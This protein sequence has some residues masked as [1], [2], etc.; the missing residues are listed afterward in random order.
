M[1]ESA[2]VEGFKSDI[3]FGEP[4]WLEALPARVYHTPQYGEVPV[5]VEKLDR[6]VANF[7]NNVRGQDIA[8]NYDH[9]ND[10]AKGNKAAGWFRDFA[11]KPSSSDPNQMSLYAAV[12]F[13]DEAQ[14]EIKSGAW[15][16]FSMEWD[17]DWMDNAG[18]SYKD[19]VVGAG[20]TNRPIAKHMQALPVNFS[21]TQ[22]QEL[23]DDTKKEFAVWSTAYVNDLP[24]SCFLYVEPGAKTKDQRHLPYKDKNGKID[25]PHLR[26]AIARIPQ[27][28]GI[29]DALKSRLQSKAR[30][31][32]AAQSKKNMSEEVAN[33][34]DLLTAQGFDVVDE[35][36]E[37][38][39]SE[40]GTGPSP[41]TDEDGSDDSAIG[42]GWRREP[43][44]LDPDDPNAP[45]SRDT[46]G[47]A[48]TDEELA[49][50][51]TKLGLKEDATTEQILA[52][53]DKAFSESKKFA[54][55]VNLVDEEK[56]FAETYPTMW[57]EHQR[58]R[59]ESNANRA[60]SFSESVS[61]LTRPE[62]D[63]MVKTDHGLSALATDKIAEVHKKFS[64]GTAS[65]TDFEEAVKTII[66]GGIVK[67]GESGSS[68]E[69][70][71]VQFDTNTAEGVANARRLFAEKVAEIR[72]EKELELAP[73]MAEAAK[74]YPELA[75]AYR[76]ATAAA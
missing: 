62:G 55:T 40:P 12:E 72:K 25:L 66:N 65:I 29:S 13:T 74:Q 16:Y 59:E 2:L 76:R 35:S 5:P 21:E 57:A 18:Q 63:K 70:E 45:K 38:E 75:E 17:D 30:S 47:S 54:E 31:I 64:E 41:R 20:I 23:D 15:K 10:R 36:K 1:L 19:V 4:V 26:N 58:M 71:P 53:A 3:E 69:K 73:A 24:N 37:W 7:K 28:K 68:Q 9:G 34:V 52:A 49:E 6:M 56:K 46:G 32:L 43:L 33:A 50:L 44:P 61:T 39:H 51:K 67:F 60:K 22:W 11:V 42:G 14:N 27:M 48:L 8:V